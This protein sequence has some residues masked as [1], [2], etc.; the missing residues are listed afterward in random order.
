[1]EP[2]WQT[3]DGRVQLFHGDALQVLLALPADSVDAV[4]TDPPYSSGGAF[5]GDRMVDSRTKYVSTGAFHNLRAFT[6]DN[7]DQRSYLAWCSLWMAAATHVAKDGAIL[8]CFTD[9]RQLPTTTDAIQA[10]GWVWRGVA[11]WQK[12]HARPCLGRYTNQCEFVAWGTNGPRET[13]G[14]TAKGWIVCGSPANADRVHMTEKPVEVMEWL[15]TPMLPESRVLDP[16]MGSGTTG[17]AAIRRG[18][19]FVGVELDQHNF[20]TAKQRMIDEIERFRLFDEPPVIQRSLL[21]PESC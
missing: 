4:I 12:V 9:W 19:S 13:E 17:V 15:A 20:A 1:M 21:E 3:D 16:F 18:L 6:G 10:G 11:T 8:S 5:R 2:T 14:P 7:R